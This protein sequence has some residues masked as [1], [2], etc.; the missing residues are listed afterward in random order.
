MTETTS[1][2]PA[3]YRTTVTPYLCATDAMAAIEFYR[4]AFGAEVTL[5]LPDAQG[6]VS[7]AT[8][9]VGDAEF[10]LSDEYP[11][12]DVRSPQTLGGSPVLIVLD[13]PDVDALFAQAIAAGATVDRPLADE[14]DGAL[15][16][17]KLIDPFGHRW[18]LS[19]TRGPVSPGS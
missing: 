12:I 5:L 15:R 9:Q 19:S 10:Y 4:Q 1:A 14:F 13:V 3:R 8:L 7:H 11:A 2:G 17:G 18:M 6:R 16:N